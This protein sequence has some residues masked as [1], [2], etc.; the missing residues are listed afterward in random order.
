MCMN[1]DMGN[2]E[3]KNSTKHITWG[4]SFD[5]KEK[6]M[7]MPEVKPINAQFVFGHVELDYGFARV[8]NQIHTLQVL[9]GNAEW[10]QI[11]LPQMR[12]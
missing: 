9:R 2:I 1:D 4:L 7:G 6:T 10:L 3:G 8:K 5:S 11:A 12:P